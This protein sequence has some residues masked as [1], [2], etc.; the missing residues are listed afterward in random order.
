MHNQIRV[1]PLKNYTQEILLEELR[2]IN[3]PDYSI[4]SN[5]NIAY[6]DLVEKILSVVDKIAPFKVLRVKNNTQ[7]WFDSE[8]AE[9]IDLRDKRLKH[10]KSTK[11]HVDEELY[12]EA[13]Y[14][15]Q[16]LI[17]EKKKQFYKEK[18]KENIGKP[19]DLWKTLKSLGLSSKKG[20]NISNI[21]LKKDGKINFDEKTNANTFKEFY[22]NLAGDLLKKLPP[23]SNKFGITSVRNFYQTILDQLPFKFKFS[24][25]T[26]DLVFKLLNDMNPDKAA[27]IDNLSGKFLKDGASILA[28]PI[29]KICNLSIKY[30]LFPTDC[31]I[32]KLK[33][34]FKKGS[35]T[36]PKN[37]RPISLLPLISKI[38]EKV[39]HDQTQE[40]L[41]TNKIL[42]K[43]QSGF[44][45]GYST[46]SC[47]SY[48]NNKIAAGFESGLHTDMILIDLQK[49]FDTINHE[50]L[51][52]KMKCLGF[53]KGVTLWFKSYL[54]NRKFKVNLNQIFSEPGNLSCGVPQGSILGPLL[55]LLNRN[56]L[57]QSVNCELLL[58]ADDTCLIFQHNDIKEIENQLNKNF[59]LI[60]EWFVDNKLSIH[61]GEDK[62]KSILF[63][64]KR[65][66]KKAS[67]LNIQYKDI[68][69]KQYSKVTYLGCILD[70]TLSGESMAIHVINKVNSRL[71]F[72][73]RQNKFLDI[74]LRRLLC[75]AMIQ[76]FFDYACNAWYP[77][78][79]KK[80]KKRLQAAQNKCIRFCLKLGDRTSIKTIEFEKINWLQIQERV[81]QC[82]RSSI[83]KFHSNIA[84]EYM[85]EVF[86][87][88]E[89]NRIPTRY[90][91]QKLKLPHRK[92]NQGLRALSYVGPFL[93]NKLDNSL[94]MSASL[95]T[96]KHNLKNQYFRINNN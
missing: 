25:V 9:A 63:S 96:F 73:C 46:D 7:E 1:R 85:D 39:I 83:H 54:S 49:A 11:L 35:T 74:P 41:D 80:F 26:E 76:L 94:K 14:Q 19:K 78:L 21:C 92:T 56:D 50:I 23:P 65:K 66:I 62:T 52:K 91:Y 29:S 5:V 8:V 77:N 89:F 42:F 48:L 45:K 75:N 12:K 31:Q 90:S 60:C 40:F 84:P 87:K 2:K 72:L 17:K 44:R 28:K 59:S 6:K 51:I 93:W 43:F 16:K 34:L 95:N 36:H 64:S 47:L 13:K 81:N 55:F 79:N 33:P 86:F 20:S 37:Y 88:A 53:S 4:F 58:Y 32:A 22:C 69:I 15:A 30:S 3:F 57:P 38:I 70:E 61:F 68:K 27:G 18:L 24:N 82:T 67:P 10:F 71:R